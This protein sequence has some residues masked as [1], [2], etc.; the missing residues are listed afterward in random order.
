MK[1]SYLV[2]ALIFLGTGLFV[3]SKFAA[4]PAPIAPVKKSEDLKLI[5]PIYGFDLEIDKADPKISLLEKDLEE[6]VGEKDNNIVEKPVGIYFRELSYGGATIGIH[7]SL[8]FAPASLFK[9]PLMMAYFKTA[10]KDP[11]FLQKKILY[12]TNTHTNEGEYFKPSQSIQLGTEYTVEDLIKSMIIYS[13]NE[14]VNLLKTD[15]DQ[16]ITN[17]TY[18]DLGIELPENQSE[19]EFMTV[20]NYASFFRIL[21]NATYLNEEFSAKA[22]NILSQS[23]FNQALTAPLPDNITAAHKFGERTVQAT[24]VKQLHDCGIIYYPS[25]PYILCVMTKGE[26]FDEQ[27]NLIRQISETVYKRIDMNYS[28]Q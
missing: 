22:L 21:Y 14:A 12:S 4:T 24:G 15:I 18:K 16:K 3:G 5:N 10:E 9:V 17:Q 28:A 20:K 27:A 23:D 19:E 26:N 25:H 8:T 2:I 7:S 11:D 6:L 1:F 13:D